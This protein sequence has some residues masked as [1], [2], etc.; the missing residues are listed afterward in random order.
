MDLRAERM[1]RSIRRN[2]TMNITCFYE[3]WNLGD[4][5]LVELWRKLW[6]DQ[7]WTPVVLNM[8]DA[9]QHP[10]FPA[11][12]ARILQ[13]PSVNDWRYE[14][15]CYYRWCAYARVGGLCVDYDILP[16]KPFPPQS[17]PGFI[18]GSKDI[19]P[20]FVAGGGE[21]Y[22][23]FLQRIL[24]Y[25]PHG[26]HVADQSIIKDNAD[27]FTETFPFAQCYSN[28][29]WQEFPLVHFANGLMQPYTKISRID[30][31]RSILKL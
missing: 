22:E 14:S 17:W 8:T 16:Q 3:P 5:P 30:Q 7:G 21:H 4:A 1:G 13:Y 2:T 23:R 20:G 6:A 12:A 27:L 19:D 15:L 31:I 18:N 9:I 10:L 28:D 25:Q 29:R 11:V 24:A 26:N